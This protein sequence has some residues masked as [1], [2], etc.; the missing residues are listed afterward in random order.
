MKHQITIAAILLLLLESCA[1]LP[2]I[3]E[4]ELKQMMDRWSRQELPDLLAP[5]AA[6]SAP[7]ARP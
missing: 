7:I 6:A 3:S 4:E 5:A 1:V 2:N